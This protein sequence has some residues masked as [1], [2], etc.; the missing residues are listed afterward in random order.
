VERHLL[1]VER[2]DL[3]GAG[4]ADSKGERKKKDGEER[5]EVKEG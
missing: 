3:G 5:D 1:D 4:G 2:Q